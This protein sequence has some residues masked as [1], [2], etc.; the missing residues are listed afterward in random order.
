MSLTN[1]ERIGR[2][3]DGRATPPSCHGINSNGERLYSYGMELA[4]HALELG[5]GLVNHRILMRDRCESSVTTRRHYQQ[6]VSGSMLFVSPDNYPAR[7]NYRNTTPI[8]VAVPFLGI[9]IETEA[10]RHL[11]QSHRCPPSAEFENEL[12]GLWLDKL[13]E[14]YGKDARSFAARRIKKFRSKLEMNKIIDAL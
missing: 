1:S 8:P 3:R 2:F 5:P 14:E 12:W 10:R 11:R 4:R 13:E 9:P 6:A 7:D